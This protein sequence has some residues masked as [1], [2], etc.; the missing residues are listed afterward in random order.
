MLVLRWMTNMTFDHRY[1]LFDLFSGC[2][3]VSKAWLLG[4]PNHVLFSSGVLGPASIHINTYMF[5]Y[6]SVYRGRYYIYTHFKAKA[7]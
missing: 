2:A 6:L 3:N 1:E 5:M 7:T 4:L